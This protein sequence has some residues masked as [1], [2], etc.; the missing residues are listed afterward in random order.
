[1]CM[2]VCFVLFCFVLFC[3]VL[4]CFV[5]CLVLF[6]LFD[7]VQLCFLI[8]TIYMMSNTHWRFSSLRRRRCRRW[9]LLALS[10]RNP[11]PKAW[12]FAIQ[13]VEESG[14]QPRPSAGRFHTNS[15]LCAPNGGANW[16][17]DTFTRFVAQILK[18]NLKSPAMR[19]SMKLAANQ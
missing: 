14:Y 4:F 16:W 15:G 7:I 3:C 5:L 2:C 17:I 12:Q 11:S 10:G 18:G 8:F 9:I 1:M 13:V 6:V 19:E